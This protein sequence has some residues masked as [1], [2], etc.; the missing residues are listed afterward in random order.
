MST[1]SSNLYTN[2]SFLKGFA[3]LGDFFTQP[4]DY[5]Y[6]EEPDLDALKRDWLMIGRDMKQ[7]IE[8]YE[9]T[10]KKETG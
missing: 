6:S 4:D 8:V 7:S 10:T 5:N 9:Q 3:R 1:Y 2:P